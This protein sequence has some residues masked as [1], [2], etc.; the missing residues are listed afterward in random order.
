MKQQKKKQQK[1]NVAKRTPK[2]LSIKSAQAEIIDWILPIVE[3]LEKQIF[4]YNN[5]TK[6]EL[7]LFH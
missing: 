7:N 5:N 2:R 3:W 6:I 4:I 1:K